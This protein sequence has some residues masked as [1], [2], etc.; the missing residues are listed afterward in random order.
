MTTP[1]LQTP[2]KSALFVD[3]DN[4][5]I[6]LQGVNSAA[7]TTFATNPLTWLRWLEEN[8]NNAVAGLTGQRRKLLLRRCYL[9]FQSFARYQRAL[10]CAAFAMTDC[11]S[12]TSNGKQCNDMYMALGL[13]DALEHSTLFDEFIIMSGDSDF[14]PILLRL[15]ERNRRITVITIGQMR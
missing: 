12:L 8:P 10:A 1:L 13:L 14:T 4:I 7:A 9:N 11:R 2:L 15:R 3:F 6:T 5:F